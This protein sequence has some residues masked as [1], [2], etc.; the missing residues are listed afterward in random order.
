MSRAVAERRSNAVA[1]GI[2]PG[3]VL[4]YQ[5]VGIV[6]L[7]R[8]FSQVLMSAVS[9]V[10][11]DDG[12]RYEFGLLVAISHVSGIEQK[13]LAAVMS[14]DVTTIGQLVDVLESKGLVRRIS[15]RTDRRVKLVEI[16]KE[17][18][19]LVDEY[20]PKVLAAQDD[21]LARLSK[22]ER[23]FLTDLM[24]RVIQANPH[25]DRPGAGRRPPKPKTE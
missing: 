16:T 12:L 6:N 7:A 3:T 20:R 13:N 18:G 24:T 23:Q 15:S 1:P 21:V 10:V 8:K 9:E 5:R 17:G 2:G 19:R 25:H 11:P 14:L 4:D 22:Q